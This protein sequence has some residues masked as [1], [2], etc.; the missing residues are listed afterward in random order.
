MPPFYEIAVARFGQ[1][2][3]SSKWVI[4][5]VFTPSS[6]HSMLYQISG[7]PGNYSLEAPQSVT[8][9]EGE[10]GYWGKVPVGR[11][12]QER[13]HR[14]SATLANIPIVRGDSS[15]SCQNWVMDAIAALRAD[16]HYIVDHATQ[17]WISERLAQL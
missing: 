4:A 6:G 14:F 15:W 10:N 2:S 1:P 16:D 12:D 9:K 11:V 3:S 7:L 13:L 17:S 8:L 5:V